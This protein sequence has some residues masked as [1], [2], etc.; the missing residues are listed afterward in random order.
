MVACLIVG[1]SIVSIWYCSKKRKSCYRYTYFGSFS[2][3]V[4][5]AELTAMGFL[6]EKCAAQ[7]PELFDSWNTLS[8]KLPFLNKTKRIVHAVKSMPQI[9][10]VDEELSKLTVWQLRRAHVCLGQLAHSYLNSHMLEKSDQAIIRAWR[11]SDATH[12]FDEDQRLDSV[13]QI[14]RDEDSRPVLPSALARPLG[15][16]CR[17]LGVP[18]VLTAAA[19][20][21]WNWRLKDPTLPFELNNLDIISSITGTDTEK[22][23]HLL[24]V[25]MHHAAASV[26]PGV[27]GYHILV[28]AQRW[29]ELQHVIESLTSLLDKFVV[30]FEQV[31]SLV[32]I[33]VFYQVYRP[34]LSGWE[35]QGLWLEGVAPHPPPSALVT[36]APVSVGREG[37]SFTNAKGPSA[38]QS[39]MFFLFDAM[40]GVR[41]SKRPSQANGFQDEQIWYLTR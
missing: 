23:F 40:L 32:D 16:V 11:S 22:N 10:R 27:L 30:L 9:P 17:Q 18:P 6:P 35:S 13:Q 24:P 38:G 3:S 12:T 28:E 4:P 33:E 34:Y 36:A 14:Q 39:A 29:T 20:D 8:E 41:C 1:A 21:L 37:R 19:L 5:T 7:L 15:F 2:R 31:Y 25:R 26:L